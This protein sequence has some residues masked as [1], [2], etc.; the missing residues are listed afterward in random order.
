[1]IDYQNIGN[2]TLVSGDTFAVRE[3][4]KAN[5]GRWNAA[6]KVW[7]VPSGKVAALEIAINTAPKATAKPAAKSARPAYAA[8]PAAS[9]TCRARGCGRPVY[10]AG[11]CR[12]CGH[13]EI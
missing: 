13:D 4:I 5:G 9:G 8:R 1:M 3:V 12:S 11:Y 7:E 10:A 2:I 6:S